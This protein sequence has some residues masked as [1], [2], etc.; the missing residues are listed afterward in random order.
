L[1]CW[2]L[3]ADCFFDT[4]KAKVKW[5]ASCTTCMSVICVAGMCHVRHRNYR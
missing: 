5:L 2:V 1:V 4:L 3:S